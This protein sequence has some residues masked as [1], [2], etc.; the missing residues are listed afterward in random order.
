MS[1]R[2]SIYIPED[3]PCS[4]ATELLIFCS[5]CVRE[6]MCVFVNVC[7]LTHVAACDRGL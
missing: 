5:V 3:F 2:N 6:K 7:A 1:V 4:V